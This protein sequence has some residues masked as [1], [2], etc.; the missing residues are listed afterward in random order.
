M[1]LFRFHAKE[2]I[3]GSLMIDISWIHPRLV[4][5]PFNLVKKSKVIENCTSSIKIIIIFPP[6]RPKFR[7]SPLVV[8]NTLF[9]MSIYKTSPWPRVKFSLRHLF[10]KRASC[11]ALS[12]SHSNV[13]ESTLLS[14]VP[15]GTAHLSVW[16]T[17]I[18]CRKT[19]RVPWRSYN[20][21]LEI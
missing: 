8:S 11:L 6:L 4:N 21:N 15:Q 9:Y 10:N 12:A 5:D 20:T 14:H 1:N 3:F 17:T 13:Y 7:L 2:L 16:V 19:N 18:A